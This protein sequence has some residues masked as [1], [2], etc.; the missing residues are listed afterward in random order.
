MKAW[1]IYG[2][3]DIKLDE[4]PSQPVGQDCVKVKILKAA[5]THTDN[6]IYEGKRPARLPLVPGRHCVAM[7]SEV[8]E[9]VKNVTRGNRVVVSPFT[10]CHD[11]AECNAGRSENCENRLEYGIAEDGFMRDFAVVH[12]ADL[13]KL[14][15]RIDDSQ[16]M[17][18]EH[19]AVAVGIINKLRLQKG[20]HIAI[21]GAT[22]TGI[23][24]AQAA[25]YYQAVPILV[26]FR[27]DR[28][29]MA[30]SLGVYYTVDTTSSDVYKKIFSLT[31]GRMAE[32]C[33]FMA[34]DIVPLT[35]TFDFCLPLGRMAIGALDGMEEL[36]ADMRT[37]VNKQLEIFG[38]S[39][40][41]KNMQ[42]AINMLANKNVGVTPL[43]SREIEFAEVKDTFDEMAALPEKYLK[44][45]VNMPK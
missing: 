28:L 26:D 11:C 19:V 13:Y 29:D 38:V 16:A 24:L 9:N 30:A 23:V 25:M 15:D 22:V 31:G 14:P 21:V 42:S 10:S 41:G 39:S 4:L 5:V 35:R 40:M 45:I 33:A 43:V 34:P 8:G 36:G 1:R 20:E 3:S 37:V 2:E 27:R 17:F 12:C 18:L 32:T 44:I 7:V 6:L